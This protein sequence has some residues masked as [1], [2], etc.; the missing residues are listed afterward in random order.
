MKMLYDSG[1]V[2]KLGLENFCANLDE[3]LERAGDGANP[4][5]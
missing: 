4:P 1:L 3:A 5:S 2:D